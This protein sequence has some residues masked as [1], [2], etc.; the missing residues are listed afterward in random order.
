MPDL[1]EVAF[2]Q[3]KK[4]GPIDLGIAAHPI[5]GLRMKRFALAILPDFVGMISVIQEN[6]LGVPILFF[7]GQ[8]GAPFKNENALSAR[9]ETLRQGAAAGA[10][11]DDDDIVMVH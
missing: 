9:S 3:S 4:G 10:R 8:E 5:S 7:P 6:G 11:S 1:F 2:P